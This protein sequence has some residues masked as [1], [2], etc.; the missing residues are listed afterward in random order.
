[1]PEI[2]TIPLADLLID[3]ENPRLPQPNVGQRDALRAIASHQG[4]KLQILAEDI[5]RHGLNPADLSIT[6]P[7]KDDPRRFLVLEGNRR[8]TALRALENPEF[9]I[10]AVEKG[11]LAKIRRLSKQYQNTPTD[12]VPCVVVTDR[13][14]AH[15]WIELR[16]TGQNSGAGIVHWE[17]HET[18]RFIART[19]GLEIHTQALNFLEKRG[20]LTPE[21][22]R[23]VP[24]TSF[25]RLIGTPEVRSRLGLDVQDG[26]LYRLADE[27]RVAQ[28]LLHIATDLASG[29][30]RTKDI[31]T[32]RQR[33]DYVS[34]LPADVLVTPTLKE[35]H[36]VPIGAETAQAK[37]RA[38]TGPK[39]PKRRDKL[40]P[41]DCALNITV[42]RL[43]EIEVELRRLSLENYA[44]AVSV[45]FRVF[46][47]LSADSYIDLRSLQRSADESLRNKLQTVTSDL[48]T[49]KK[50]TR[51]QATPV[52]RA[53]QKDSFLAPSVTM[54][55]QFVHNPHVFP[56][57]SDLRA[58][59]DG[60]QP[61]VTAIWSP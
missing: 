15:H 13:N 8:L 4:R 10:G 52:R 60:L 38:A 2:T 53:M 18:E 56:A 41:R 46:L 9:L 36:G 6:M 55:H 39:L 20:D 5:L 28:A 59:W 3:A 23:A 19:G 35:G 42:P 45:L 47:E 33:I 21:R 30:T 50:L 7:F 12:S 26:K 37:S 40:I 61:F 57:P 49:R 48:V 29:K 25:R 17:R 1:M 58:H 34:K 43:R 31:Y 11:V 51:Q 44:N 16:H 32:Q 54:M 14:E 24:A 27:K 22:R